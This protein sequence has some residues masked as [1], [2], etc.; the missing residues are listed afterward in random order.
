[1]L[2]ALAVC[3]FR[4]VVIRPGLWGRGIAVRSVLRFLELLGFSLL[5]VF[6]LQEGGCH[7]VNLVHAY[8]LPN[9]DKQ[10]GGEQRLVGKL[11]QPAKVLHVRV[12]L[13]HLYRFL[14]GKIEFV[15]YNHRTDYHAGRLVACTLVFVSKT[16]IVSLL[17]LPPT[18]DCHQEAPNGWSCSNPRKK[19]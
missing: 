15:L 7:L 18:E 8:A 2:A 11:W 17:N 16:G 13:Y 10:T 1:M 3:K 14:V 5:L 4:T 19:T 12:L 9:R 6:T